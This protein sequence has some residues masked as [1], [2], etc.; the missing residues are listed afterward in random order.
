MYDKYRYSKKLSIRRSVQYDA[1]WSVALLLCIR[2]FLVPHPMHHRLGGATMVIFGIAAFASGDRWGF[3]ESENP[4]LR[5]VGWTIVLVFAMA[6]IV[7]GCLEF[8]GK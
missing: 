5:A 4:A 3:T 7:G 6:L 8:V 2:F 1:L